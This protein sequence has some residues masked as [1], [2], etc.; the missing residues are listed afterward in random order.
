MTDLQRLELRMGDLRK[1]LAEAIGATE[2]D[3]EAI[4]KLTGEI[5]ATDA[6]LVAQK[7]LEP[8]PKPEVTTAPPLRLPRNGRWSNYAPMSS[9]AG[10]SPLPWPVCLS[11]AGPNSNTTSTWASRRTSSRR[12]FWPVVGW[13]TGR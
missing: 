4:E 2:P 12:N 10:T 8:E 6:L 5:R 11:W 3:T 9:L 7:V 1:Q 13:N